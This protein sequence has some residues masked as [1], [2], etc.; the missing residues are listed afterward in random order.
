M[1]PAAGRRRPQR[2]TGPSSKTLRAKP[3][4]TCRRAVSVPVTSARSSTRINSPTRRSAATIEGCAPCSAGPK[5][6]GSSPTHPR[7]RRRR[8]RLRRAPR[9]SLRPSWRRS[10][11]RTEASS[12]RPGYCLMW[13]FLF[14]QG[15]RPGEMYELRIRNVGLEAEKW[16]GRR[17]PPSLAR[18]LLRPAVHF[19]RRVDR[20]AFSK[21][22]RSGVWCG[23]GSAPAVLELQACRAS[24]R[25]R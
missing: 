10:A 3:G 14:Y 24:G 12:T 6:K 18:A 2:P 9:F 11:P 20:A 1:R 15:L 21:A 16:P 19:R 17:D 8:K 22:L 4:P 7:C 5:S 25:G 23:P 13:R